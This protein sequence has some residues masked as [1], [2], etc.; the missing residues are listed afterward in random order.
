MILYFQPLL[1]LLA[2]VAVMGCPVK[3]TAE[4]AVQVVEAGVAIQHPPQ[5]V[6]QEILRL[7]HPLK[8]I[9]AGLDLL[10]AP[11]PVQVVAVEHLLL[12]VT[13]LQ[14]LEQREELVPHPQFLAHL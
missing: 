12:A 14:T 11:R 8:V 1:L 3:R 9:T 6:D 13:E 4:M 2:A 7:L 5:Q 10:A